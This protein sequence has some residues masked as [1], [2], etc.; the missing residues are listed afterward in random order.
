MRSRLADL[1]L[2]A[3]DDLIVAK[4]AGEIDSSNAP[5]LGKALLERLSNSVRGMVLDITEV[6]YLDS[7]GIALIFDLARGLEARRQTLRVAV[8][9]DGPV[10]RVLDL[11][12]IEA[13]AALDDDA[14]SAIAALTPDGVS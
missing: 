14:D 12:A 1:D 4:V 13:V 7:T 9:G 10:R 6:S 11:C 8:A 3:T 2:E 5:D